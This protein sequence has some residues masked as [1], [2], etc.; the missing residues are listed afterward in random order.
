M[1]NLY[2]FLEDE[3]LKDKLNDMIKENDFSFYR[4]QKKLVPEHIRQRNNNLIRHVVD[5]TSSDILKDSSLEDL[6]TY[7]MKNMKIRYL[8]RKFVCI[9]KTKI[10]KRRIIGKFYR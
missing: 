3:T 5:S 8:I 1:E 4:W 10:A 7:Y 6:E 9:V 2:F